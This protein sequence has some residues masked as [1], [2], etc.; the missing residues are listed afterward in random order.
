M[1][2]T[3]EQIDRLIESLHDFH[4]EYGAL[5]ALLV[6]ERE[7][8]L[9]GNYRGFLEH[10]LTERDDAS[11]AARQLAEDYFEQGASFALLMASFNHLKEEVIRLVA[12]NMPDPIEHYREIDRIFERAKRE[13]A[14]YYLINEVETP[15][16]LPEAVVR[17]RIL[18]KTYLEWVERIRQGIQQNLELFPLETADESPFARVLRYPESLLICLDLKLC[19]QI[20]EQHRLI[21]QQ[22]GILYA[23][24]SANRYEQAYLAYNEL[25]KKVAQLLNLLTVLYLEGQTNRIGRFFSFLQASLYLPGR[26]FLCI[27]NLRK[28]DTINKLYGNEVGDRALAHVDR[29]L[30]AEFEQHQEWM[31]YTKGI[32]GDFYVMGYNAEPEAL[33]GVL[34]NV[35]KNLC[36]GKLEDLPVDIDI[37][38]HG[39]ELTDFSELTTENIHLVVQYL[40]EE[41]RKVSEHIGTRDEHV[42][43]MVDWLKARYR[44]SLDLRAKLTEEFTDIFIQPLVSLDQ[45]REILAFEI[46][47][48]FREND[49]FIS[50][51]L[52]ID[53]IISMGLTPE[54][55]RLVLK[56]TARQAAMLTHITPRL[57]IN[58]S[59][60]SLASQ[61]YLDLLIETLN[62]PLRDFEVVLELTEQVLL[63][64]RG[65]VHEL[66]RK[67][68]LVFAVDD[69]GTGYSTLQ[70]V[71]ELALE[72]SVR[73]LKL[74]GSLTRN[75]GTSLASEHIMLITRQMAQRLGLETVVEF[76]ETIEQ[77]E[78]LESLEM[79]FGQG[80]L[81]GVPDPVPV[82]RGKINYLKSKHAGE[83][84]GGF[85]L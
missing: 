81:L 84:A 35:R 10:F 77:A 64:H 3:P 69:F 38:Y 11:E 14:R 76:I 57:F 44:K 25:M 55:D 53:D 7:K 13:T 15:H 52:F 83:Q 16:H 49:G 74:D 22:A 70:T 37:L 72:G 23:M 34:E 26:K 73:Y 24:L 60:A 58:V 4:G 50:A 56:A 65:L 68:D 71:V 1:H 85:A 33:G 39:I 27:V 67:Y 47:G 29:L 61:D 40:T 59:A 43:A 2:L 30:H 20:Q 63:E 51:G 31:F 5:D 82:W 32:A 6:E 12:A 17:D 80:Y 79:D 8:R 48:R 46:L 42:Q 9:L 41:A 54:F 18:I 19:D 21:F 75:I 45:R 36:C 66:H 62:G 78:K 28:L